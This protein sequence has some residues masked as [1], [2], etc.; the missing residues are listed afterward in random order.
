MC[1]KNYIMMFLKKFEIRWSD[2][3]PNRH[4]ANSAYINFMSATRMDYLISKG[5]DQQ[6]M[7]KYKIGPII[8]KEQ[9]HYY[10]EAFQG[11]PIYVSLEIAGM[12]ENGAFF[13]FIHNFYDHKGAHLAQGE[14]IGAWMNLET[15]K[16]TAL[17]TEFLE[18]V[19][20]LHKTKEY[21]TLTKEDTRTPGKIPVAIELPV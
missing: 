15:R 9:I 4:L 8:F 19:T 14:M 18:I 20:D 10:Q 2:L 3:D 21:K 13:S 1:R 12:S 11:K 17:P 7:R 16:T 6:A 5:F